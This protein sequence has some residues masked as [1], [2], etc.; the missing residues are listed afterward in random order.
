MV[1]GVEVVTTHASCIIQ[2]VDQPAKWPGHRCMQRPS[3]LRKLHAYETSP[4]HHN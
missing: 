3:P 1:D 4:M 2:E